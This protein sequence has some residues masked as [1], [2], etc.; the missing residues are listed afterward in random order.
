MDPLKQRNETITSPQVVPKQQRNVEKNKYNVNI[1]TMYKELDLN[2]LIKCRNC[3]NYA[4]ITREQLLLQDE[5]TP[6]SV[7]HDLL[8]TFNCNYCRHIEETIK[9]IQQNM[10]S[11]N[12][13]IKNKVEVVTSLEKELKNKVEEVAAQTKELSALKNVTDG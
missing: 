8:G 13:E 9:Q 4:D 12:K 7:I 5:A 3:G 2:N 6:N 11:L 1:H 10:I